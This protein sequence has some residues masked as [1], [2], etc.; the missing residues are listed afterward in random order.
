MS[1]VPV[2]HMTVVQVVDVILVDHCFMATAEATGVVVLLCRAVLGC[3]G[4]VGF[5]SAWF[6][7]SRRMCAT[8]S[9]ASE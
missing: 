4:H 2:M 1:V 3:R 8:C 6:Q 9:S 5:S 7:A